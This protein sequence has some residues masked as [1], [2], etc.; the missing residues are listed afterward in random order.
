MLMQSGIDAKPGGF[1]SIF[2]QSR[3]RSMKM[4]TILRQPPAILG[5]ACHDLGN[6]A[7]RF[8]PD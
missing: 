8:T 2:L 6:E 4:G 3:S 1:A 5:K 7:H